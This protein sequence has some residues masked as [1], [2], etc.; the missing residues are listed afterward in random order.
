MD[1]N[2]INGA[3]RGVARGGGG[4]TLGETAGSICGDTTIVAPFALVDFRE[5][6]DDDR[7]LPGRSRSM[8]VGAGAR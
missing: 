3:A 4:S 1:D 7:G 6:S 5:E 8:W 2:G